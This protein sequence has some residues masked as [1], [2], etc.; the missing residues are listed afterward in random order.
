MID[1]ITRDRI[2][3]TARIEEVVGDYIQLHKR[4]SSYV[5]LCPFHN[6]RRP[7]FNVSPAKNICKCFVCEAGGNPATFIMQIEHK[8]FYDALRQLA[9]KYGI[10]IEEREETEE[11]KLRRDKRESLFLANK[12]AGE[13]FMRRLKE[14]AEGKALA[15]TYLLNRGITESI[16]QKF[17]LGY[18]TSE[19]DA[20][21]REVTKAGYKL[22]AFVEVGLCY[23]GE[24]GRT[25]ADRFRE[26]IIFPVHTISGRIVAFG[27][28]IMGKSDKLAKY[29][30]SPESLVYSKSNELYG[31]FLGKRAISKEN[32]CI[33]VEGYM[34]VIALH[35]VGI[36][37]VVATSG[38]AL[39]RQ[40]V[41]HI[42]RL[43]QNVTVV[44][45][46]DAAGIKAAIRGVDL[47]LPA[48]LNIKILVLPDGHDPDS[49][50]RA[51]PAEEVRSYFDTQ[52]Q[53]FISFKSTLWQ[54][55]IKDNPQAR[56]QLINDLLHSIALIP[57]PIQ[58][59]VY[60]QEVSQR[61]GIDEKLLL[62][63]VRNLRH[64]ATIAQTHPGYRPTPVQSPAQENNTPPLQEPDAPTPQ[65][66]LALPPQN[67]EHAL[68]SL[69]VR[70]G[71]KQLTITTPSTENEAETVSVPLAVL[72]D[73]ELEADGIDMGTPIFKRIVKE[74]SLKLQENPELVCSLYFANHPNLYICR[75][76]VDLLSSKY[77]LSAA[78]R[79]TLGFD[80]DGTPP[81]EELTMQTIKEIYA[82]KGAYIQDQIKQINSQIAQ[83]QQQ[84]NQ[85]E[86]DYLYD[87]LITLNEYKRSFSPD[88]GDRTLSS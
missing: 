36:E 63:Q 81:L 75:L 44:F 37:N 39:T 69:V 10:P 52:A 29:I 79:R 56:A 51:Y 38:T 66:P 80:D 9:Q 5:G 13:F 60:L 34:D 1:D 11:D 85:T 83:A 68:L 24:E 25:P 47:L 31:L 7:S 61:F 20:L 50:S 71:D 74:A 4:G 17:G 84:G 26:R 16:A 48:G 27:G 33:I 57:E 40:Q 23:A 87:R 32:R 64:Q 54:Q 59:S 28:R 35:Q 88:L 58:R 30:N 19:R 6:D 82:F 76:A 18:A 43:A 70:Y 41:Q 14:S 73:S 53:D 72:V 77:N 12:V 78:A 55:D 3:E 8:S 49:F 15:Q 46:G 45:D 42:R 65:D 62:Q 2:L 22:D 86:I 21:V 67:N